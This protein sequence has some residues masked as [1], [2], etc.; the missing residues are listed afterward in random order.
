[1][2]ISCSAWWCRSISTRQRLNNKHALIT[3]SNYSCFRKSS[4]SPH[5]LCFLSACRLAFD[6]F[7]NFPLFLS[8]NCILLLCSF[9]WNF[10][11]LHKMTMT[12]WVSYLLIY[13]V[14]KS[15]VDLTSKNKKYRVTEKKQSHL[16][17]VS[18][19][20]LIFI[21]DE[22]TFLINNDVVLM[23][24][25]KVYCNLLSYNRDSFEFFN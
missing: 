11:F 13:C 8:C 9:L 20:Y 16:I 10:L 2:L 22:W 21:Y 25:G 23:Y 17:Q 15:I 18:F 6:S 14:D 1:M 24:Y 7:F 5:S 4:F 12:E 19:S 3:N